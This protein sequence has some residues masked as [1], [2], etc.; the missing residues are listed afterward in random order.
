MLV[1]TWLGWGLIKGSAPT[2]DEPVH[3]AS[4]FAALRS[5]A[6]PLNYRDHPPFAEMWAALPLLAL[7]PSTGF[8][9]PDWAAGRVYNYSDFFLY[10]NRLSA[11]KLLDAARLWCLLTWT[12]VLALAALE[13][14]RRLAGPAGLWASAWLLAFC[15]P[16][17]SNAALVATDAAAAALYFLT[18][19]LLSFEPRRRRHWLLAGVSCGLALA[20]KFN[21]VVIPLF[22]ASAWLSE[23]KVRRERESWSGPWL[24]ASAALL[25]LASVYRF[26]L[27]LYWEGLTQT[28]SRLGQGR[29]SFLHG[30]HSTT[31]FLLYFPA[32][33]ALK[34]PLALLAASGAGLVLWMRRPTPALLWPALPPIAFFAAACLSK[35]QIGYRHILP[36]YPFLIVMGA[37]AASWAWA[38]PPWGRGAALGLGLWLAVS[39]LRV[40]PHHLAY[41]N[42]LSGGPVGGHRWLVDSNLDWGQGLKELAGEIKRRGNPPVFLSYF[43]AADPFYYGLRYLPVG[44]VT[45]VDRREGVVE[46]GPGDPVL[47]AV[48]A[49]NLQGVYFQEKSLFTWL[50]DRAPD[51]AAGYSIF[52]Y[53]LTADAEGRKKLAALVELAGSPGAARRLVLK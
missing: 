28:F 47:L 34:T 2:Y 8:S 35:T 40:H 48:S 50:R 23:R 22:A 53:D 51:F 6:R 20:S 31:G 16:L 44:F 49:T 41:F 30:A 45:N 38:K 26:R 18:F 12:A 43:G 15:P 46:P 14:S 9:H 42:E 36:V 24:M 5:P 29:A 10:K 19:W 11:E 33:L 17:L 52:L 39:V 32:A 25:I 37:C 13:W 4:G 1:S 7:K 27:P 21:M 3:L